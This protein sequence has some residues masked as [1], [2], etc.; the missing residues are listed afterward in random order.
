METLFNLVKPHFD[1]HQGTVNVEFELRLGKVNNKMFD[2]NVGEE[3]FFRIMEALEKYG[4]WEDVKKSHTSVYYKDST[5]II[6]DE[7]TDETVAMIKK[8]IIKEN[9]V[10]EGRPLDVRFAVSTENTIE[11]ADADVMDFVRVKKR[12]SYIRKNLSID[13]TIVSG[14]SDDPDDENEHRYEIE[15]EIIDPQRVHN[16]NDLYNIIHK[17]QNILEVL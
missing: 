17:V 4:A 1:R 11:D 6:V 16:D 15:M 8:P 9:L 3:T 12:T 5:R 2:T 13:M 7:D 14:Q 10:L